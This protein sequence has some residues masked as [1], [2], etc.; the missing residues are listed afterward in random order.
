MYDDF[1]KGYCAVCRKKLFNGKKVSIVLLFEAAKD[2]NLREN[3]NKTKRL[4]ISG[5]QHIVL[6]EQGCWL[7]AQLNLHTY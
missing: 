3:Q 1:D 6:P 7:H 4:S 5:V 2:G